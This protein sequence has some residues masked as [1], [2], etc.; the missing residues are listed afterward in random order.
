MQTYFIEVEITG[1]KQFPMGKRL[2]FIN[3]T[4][5]KKGSIGNITKNS[6]LFNTSTGDKIKLFV[7][8]GYYKTYYPV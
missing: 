3:P 1:K 6:I 2:Y 4:N 5:N 7:S 8:D